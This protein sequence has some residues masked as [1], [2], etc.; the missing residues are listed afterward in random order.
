MSD[1]PMAVQTRPFA[2][3]PVTQVM[4]PDGIFDNALYNL[5]ISC[6]Y[7]NTSRQTLNNVTVYLESV[8]D[9]GVAVTAQ[10]FNLGT[11]PAGASVLLQWK[12]N[13]QY[14]SPGKPL[15]SFVAEA[16]GFASS[17]SIQQIFVS[18]TRYDTAAKK[19]T[20]TIPEGRLEVTKMMGIG[21]RAAV[22]EKSRLA[23][24]FAITGVDWDWYP[25]PS[26]SGQ[27]GDLPF[28]DPWWKILAVVVAILALIVGLIAAAV[29]SGTFSVGIGGTFNDDPS[30][31]S[32]QCCKP[33]PSTTGGLTVAGVCGAICSGA[34]AVACSD[35]ADPVYRG[36]QNTIPKPNELTIK[37]SVSAHWR[38]IEPPNA[39]KPYK[40]KV[41]WTYTR[42]TTGATYNYDV[43]EE[44]TNIHVVK[45]VK[46]VTPTTVTEKEPLW[47]KVQF[48]KPDGTLYQGPELYTFCFFRSPEPHGLFFQAPLLDDGRG[49]D[50]AANDGTYTAVLSLADARR[51]IADAG[52]AVEGVWQVFIYAQEVNR[53]L[54]G[55]APVLA[56]QTVGGNFVASAISI[57]FDPSLPCPLKA[58]AN[59][60]VT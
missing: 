34:I 55:T 26:Y 60:T 12:G 23:G 16:D 29:G 57:T 13:F 11:V 22:D 4:L 36:Q 19:W 51:Y 2:V 3:E 46:V 9:P 18:Q 6:H 52:G 20:C 54:P 49:M 15:V 14:A 40:T 1:T 42:V 33:K 31:P 45:N 25:N 43:D 24:P 59:I 8:G 50:T 30:A 21:S 38:F 32:I 48:T 58:E 41:K 56:A 53:T 28:S 47:A 37:E 7:T 5:L 10:T 17:R 39:G 44:Q 27:F 35:A